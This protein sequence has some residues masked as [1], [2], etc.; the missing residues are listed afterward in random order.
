MMATHEELTA[1]ETAARVAAGAVARRLLSHLGV[2]ITSHV[3]AIGGAALSDPL[4]VTSYAAAEWA[5]VVQAAHGEG[6]DCPT[7]R[8]TARK[9]RS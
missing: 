6:C 8:C 2:E 9:D 7:C 3:T 5:G 4:A 1:R